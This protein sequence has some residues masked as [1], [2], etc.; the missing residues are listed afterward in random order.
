MDVLEAIR[1]RRSV[2][3]FDPAH[4][5][6]E[7]EI[8]QLMDHV[9]LSPTAFNIQNWRFV[10]VRDRALRTEIRKAAWDQLQVT[11]ASLL[12]VFC[13]DLKSWDKSPERYWVNA[14]AHVSESMVREIRHFYRDDDTLQRDEGMRSCGMAAQTAMLAAKAMGYES[15]PMDG[16]DFKRVG[17]LINLPPD[18]R[19]CM[20]LCI[21]KPLADAHPR[22]GQ[23]DLDA[24][25]MD[26]GFPERET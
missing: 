5:M 8:R 21:G 10:A 13:M 17:H 9:I 26:D 16:F 4:R 19:I 23:L 22:A 20:M 2:R 25:F 14:P 12:L 6:S 11:D 24:V 18:H 1:R 3:K 7:A 15:C